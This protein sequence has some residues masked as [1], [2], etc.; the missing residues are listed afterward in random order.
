[1]VVL[2][3]I[4]ATIFLAR[5]FRQHAT[6][7]SLELLMTA[8]VLA[9]FVAFLIGSALL[10]RSGRGTRDA[11]RYAIGIGSI[12]PLAVYAINA[13]RPLS[14]KAA[15]I[16]VVM[17]PMSLALAAATLALGTIVRRRK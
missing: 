3:A 5:A 1:M 11:L 16:F 10:A 6:P 17:P 7:P 2:S 15:A 13:A 8:W 9:P 12:V 4:G 14:E